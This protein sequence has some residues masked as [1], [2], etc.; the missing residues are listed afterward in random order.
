MACIALTGKERFASHEPTNKTVPAHDLHARFDRAA[1]ELSDQVVAWRHHLHNHP[2]LSNRET[3]T[4][5]MIADHLRSL[6]LDE[7]RTGI[8]GHGVVGVLRGGKDGD[9]VAALRADIDALPLKEESGVDF[10]STV[11]DDDYPGGPYPVAHACGH[12]CHTAMLMGAASVLAQARD[13]L[14]GTVLFV[15]QPAE[16]G[17]CPATTHSRSPSAMSRTWVAST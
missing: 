11:V 1:A 15:F 10:A 8:A 3:A 9:H 4:G 13:E 14:P 7:V 6:E 5:Q 17:N 12:D 2:E 16:E